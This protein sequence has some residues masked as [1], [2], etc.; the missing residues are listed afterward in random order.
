MCHLAIQQQ[1]KKAAVGGGGEG[2]ENRSYGSQKCS[3]TTEKAAQE[4]Q[5][6]DLR[7]ML[8]RE[9]KASLL[10]NVYGQAWKQ[11]LGGLRGRAPMVSAWKGQVPHEHHCPSAGP[12]VKEASP[13]KGAEPEALVP[14]W[15][16]LELR[17][18]NSGK[19][20]GISWFK[21]VVISTHRS[22]C[23]GWSGESHF[24]IL[25]SA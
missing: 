25:H 21:S 10:P 24:C 9:K 1:L 15:Q 8:E 22:R 17:D 2:D 16:G 11:I 3:S 14:V 4:Q 7:L 5:K 20:T 23:W 13:C 6:V 12:S 18:R 19:H